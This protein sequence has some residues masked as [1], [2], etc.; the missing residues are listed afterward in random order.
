MNVV[1]IDRDGTIIVEPPDEQIDSLEKLELIPHAIEGLRLLRDRGFELVMVTN[2]DGLGTERYPLTSFEVPQ[3]KLLRILAGEGITFSQVF[4]C[5][6]MPADQCGCRKPKTGLLDRYLKEQNPD[7]SRSFVLGDRET[8]VQLGKNIGCSTVRL[9]S[10]GQS[11]AA[12]ITADFL[13]ACRF[14][15]RRVRSAHVER[16]TAETSISAE[17]ILDGTGSFAINTGVGFFDHM[18]AQLSKHSLIDLTLTVRGDLHVD[19]HHTVE[20]TG[21]AIGSAIRQALGDKRGI[22]RY[23]FYLP[24]DESS[25]QVALDLSDRPYFVLNG[26]F[27]R[28]KVGEFPTELVEDFFRALADGLRA[29]LHI[30]VQGRNDHHKIE[31]MFKSVARTLKQA[32]ALDQRSPS[33]LPSTKGTL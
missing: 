14:M 11:D 20:D 2:Q 4:V 13:E 10:D 3:K 5:P 26:T 16:V 19:E 27:E 6:H 23:G 12:F 30:T 31:A 8:D 9:S 1:F 33:T 29:N 22:E 7:L 21:L 18:L 24:M 32:V 15:A 25:A 28:E 17:V